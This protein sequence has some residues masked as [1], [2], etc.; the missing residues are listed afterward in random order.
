MS[1]LL[2]FYVTSAWQGVPEA[3]QVRTKI[4]RRNLL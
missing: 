3:A 1:L 4:T 2:Q